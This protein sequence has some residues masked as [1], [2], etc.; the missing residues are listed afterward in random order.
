MV[1]KN[2]RV[3]P[4]AFFMTIH[5]SLPAKTANGAYDLAVTGDS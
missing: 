2:A 3:L 1:M 4:L 5:L